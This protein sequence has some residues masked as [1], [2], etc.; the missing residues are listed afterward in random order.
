MRRCYVIGMESMNEGSHLGSILGFVILVAISGVSF[1]QTMITGAAPVTLLEGPAECGDSCLTVEI[2]VDL[3]GLSGTG[4]VAGLNAFVLAFDLDRSNVY[5]SARAGT[6]PILDWHF[7]RTNREHV[8]TTDRLILV[9]AVSDMTAPNQSYHVATVVFCG[10]VGDV[11]LTFVPSE[12][13][14]GS[15]LVNGDGPGPIPIETPIPFTVTITTPFTLDL[16]M[17]I[18][19]WLSVSPA[20]DLVNPIGPIDILDLTKLIDCGR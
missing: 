15:R 6:L 9:G 10:T 11:T 1:A 16:A 12:S 13:S 17:G 20:Y 8:S 4:G 7:V 18:S 5:A 3:T 19:L 14:L 2:Q